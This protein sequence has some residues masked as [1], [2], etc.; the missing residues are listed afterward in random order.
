MS[1][2]T[3]VEVQYSDPSCIKAA[4]KDLGYVFEEHK[5]AQQLYGYAGDLREQVA[6]II[7]RRKY[8]GSAANDVGFVRKAN[9]NYELIISEFDRRKGS[10]SAKNFLESMKQMY[11]KHKALKQL[12]KMGTTVTSIKSTS[13]FIT[14]RAMG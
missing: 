7:I 6:H 5:T 9:G 8:V 3:I 2:Y 11:G 4:L 13:G 14:I 10:L 1:E 12:K